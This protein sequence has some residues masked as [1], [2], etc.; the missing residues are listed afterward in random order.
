MQGTLQMQLAA[1]ACAKNYKKTFTLVGSTQKIGSAGLIDT[2]LACLL[3]QVA[4]DN[5]IILD[6][7][8]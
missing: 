6:R 2:A 5:N 4:L 3:R 8:L 7:P 1:K